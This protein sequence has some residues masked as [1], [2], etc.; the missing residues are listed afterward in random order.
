MKRSI[1]KAYEIVVYAL[2]DTLVRHIGINVTVAADSQHKEILREFED[3]TQA[4]IGISTGQPSVT[5]PARL[6]RAG[7]VNAADRGLDM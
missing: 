4:V 5:F 2:F 6:Y 7:V 1:D 3:F